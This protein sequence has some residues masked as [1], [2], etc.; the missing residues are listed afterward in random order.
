MWTWGCFGGSTPSPRTRNNSPNLLSRSCQVNEQSCGERYRGRGRRNS[1]SCNTQL[2]L[3]GWPSYCCTTFEES[4]YLITPVTPMELLDFFTT[5][6]SPSIKDNRPRV[7]KG[8]NLLSSDCTLWAQ[9]ERHPGHNRHTPEK[10]LNIL[11][12]MHYPIVAAVCLYRHFPTVPMP[13][14]KHVVRPNASYKILPPHSRC[15]SKLTEANA[16]ARHGCRPIWRLFPKPRPEMFS[17]SNRLG[18][19]RSRQPS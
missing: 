17:F 11:I 9:V 15:H 19:A 1:A 5:E 4:P 16:S 3:P 14:I 13:T 7:V 8:N 10:H 18:Q 2:A 6:K 12:A